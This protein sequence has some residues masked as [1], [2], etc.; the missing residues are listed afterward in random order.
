MKIAMKKENFSVIYYDLQT[1]STALEFIGEK[2][3]FSLRYSQIMD[4]VITQD[5]H[6]KSYFTMLAMGQLYEGAI[7]DARDIEPFAAALKDKLDGV[8]NIE[9]RRS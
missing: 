5:R 9:I 6:G 8:I 7:L 2:E 1:K 3:Q 4:F